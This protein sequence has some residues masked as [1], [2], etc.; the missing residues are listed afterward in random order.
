MQSLISLF[1]QVCI[2]AQPVVQQ[3]AIN[4]VSSALN[5]LKNV[6]ESSS[7]PSAGL[8]R[9]LAGKCDLNTMANR[10]LTGVKRQF[11]SKLPVNL[12]REEKNVKLTAYLQSFFSAFVKAFRTHI[13]ESYSSPERLNLFKNSTMKINRSFLLGEIRVVELSFNKKGQGSPAVLVEFHIG[14][15]R[16]PGASGQL[17]IQDIRIEGISLLKTEEDI[18]N[19]LYT[20]Y[21]GNMSQ[22]IQEYQVI[23]TSPAP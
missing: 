7:N 18:V 8:G 20:Q 16:A 6:I 10:I 9:L 1:C 3:E 2:C 15:S 14:Y 22:V 13:L 11:L 23:K 4:F 17:M 19:S 21:R 12:S 5:E